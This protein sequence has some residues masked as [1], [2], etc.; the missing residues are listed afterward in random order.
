MSWGASSPEPI[1]PG[2]ARSS[3]GGTRGSTRLPPGPATIHFSEVSH[4][5][6]PLFSPRFPQYRYAYRRALG[7]G[8][9]QRS[10]R[11]VPGGV[12]VDPERLNPG[13]VRFPGWALNRDGGM[14]HMDAAGKALGVR[15]PVEG[16]YMASF[17]RFCAC[18]HAGP[19]FR[20]VRGAAGLV[21]NRRRE[22]IRPSSPRP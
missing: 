7:H 22:P 14:A 13:V 21:A 5:S 15:L 2:F 9:Q 6:H 4:V 12:P 17:V 11:S 19:V 8:M 16:G 3:I 18:P 1:P 10:D 20:D